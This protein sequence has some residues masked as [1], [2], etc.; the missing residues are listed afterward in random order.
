MRRVRLNFYVTGIILIMLGVLIM[1]YP[2]EAIMSAGFVMGIGL[3]ASGL[4]YC[5]G[6]YFFRLKR[7]ILLGILDLLMGLYMTVQPGVTA[8]II[9]F[10]TGLWLLLTGISRTGMSLWL[11]GAKISGW[12]L[13]LLIGI[14]SILLAA[15]MFASPVVG[16]LYIMMIT[17]GVLIA[18]GILAILEGCVMFR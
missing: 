6:Y 14:I 13:M 10:A 9:P 4:N 17:A 11:G 1:R 15:L 5:S 12:W 16:A 7:F 18:S 8:L 3:I 2:V